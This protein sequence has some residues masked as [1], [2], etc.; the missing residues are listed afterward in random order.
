MDRRVA[1]VYQVMGGLFAIIY[2]AST[3]LP[4]VTNAP[5]RPYSTLLFHRLS[6]AIGRVVVP[7]VDA[8]AYVCYFTLR[9]VTGAILWPFA[10]TIFSKGALH[11]WYMQAATILPGEYKHMHVGWANAF[12]DSLDEIN[13]SQR[14]QEE[15]VLWLS[16]MPLNPSESKAVV[17]SLALISS[18]RPHQFPK[19][20]IVFLNLTLESA[21]REDP[22]QEQTDI[23]IDCVLVLGHIKFQSVVDRNWDQDRSIGGIPVTA[24]VAWAAQQLTISA[25]QTNFN[26]P[27]SEG[28]R[29]RLLTAAAWLSPVDGA[30]DV[31][32][33]GESLK[34]QD[35]WQFIEKIKL[36]LECHV[37]SD[38]P[39]DNKVLINLIHGM[40]ACIPRGNYGSASSIVSFLPLL[41]E[42]YDS[43]WSEDET[44]LRALITYALDLLLPPEKRKPLVEREIEF[45]KLASELID[46]LIV[47]TTYTDVVA[48]GFWLIYRV[49][50][51]FKSRKTMLVDIAHIWAAT[52]EAIPEDHHERMNFHAIDAF[53]AVAQFHAAAN[54]TLPKLSPYSALKLLKAAHE[55][56][57]S[58]AMATYAIAMVLNL[59]T[60]TQVATF[61]SEITAEP[62]VETLFSARS[63]LEKNA[64]EEDIVDL[65]I[66]SALILLKFQPIELDVGKVKGL[67]GQMEKTLGDAVVRDSGV[68]RVSGVEADLDRV[69]W[70][71]IYLSALLFKFVP[72]A[73]REKHVEGFRK[74]VRALL[75]SGELLVVSDYERCLE[76]LVMGELELRTPAEQRG[77]IYTAFEVW[78]DD[79]PLFPLAGSVTRPVKF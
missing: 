26:T 5:F 48:F 9:F 15:A 50:Y 66:Y 75:R 53:V 76:P 19:S 36:T 41:C 64:A 14:V 2:F 17:S 11:N 52:N 1:I 78:I 39:L 46:M 56:D 32:W 38:K 45:S 12:N 18:S 74:R 79:F 8:F 7:I 23:A 13:T 62:F 37:R 29:A 16:Q 35:R 65:H 43:P 21:F 4:F 72:E 73:E 51:A 20:V 59:G 24:S 49:P 68:A 27:H 71:A 61:M 77:R 67:I 10:Q 22:S 40:H 33:S 31:R 60:S 44:V 54:N 70:K 28:I 34:I 3:F 47:N 30:E 69:R 25:F 57:Y 42:D 58:R 55:Y 6:V 63:D